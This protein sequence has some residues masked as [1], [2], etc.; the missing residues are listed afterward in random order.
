[1]VFSHVHTEQEKVEAIQKA[2][3]MATCGDID[4]LLIF[5]MSFV[6]RHFECAM[7][8][9]KQL[10]NSG[11]S[12]ITCTGGQV[13]PSDKMFQLFAAVASVELP[14]GEEEDTE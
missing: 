8:R 2:I 11:I 3:T 13:N 10:D 14:C 12:I 9:L 7:E 1:M 5:D 6:S 4:T